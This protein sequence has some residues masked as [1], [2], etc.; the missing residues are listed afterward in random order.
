MLTT[1]EKIRTALIKSGL[2][3]GALAEKLG[4]S[5]QN[6][7]NKLSRDNFTVAEMEQIAAALDITFEWCFE[8]PDGTKI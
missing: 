6:L 4:Q 5:R 8:F 7:S 3:I 2:T 1:S